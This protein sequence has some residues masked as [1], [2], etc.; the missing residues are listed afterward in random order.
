MLFLF[1]YTH[2]CI[3]TGNSNILYMGNNKHGGDDDSDGDGDGDGEGGGSRT[4]HKMYTF[5]VRHKGK[6]A[7]GLAVLAGICALLWAISKVVSGDGDTPSSAN[8]QLIKDSVKTEVNER[9]QDGISSGNT[10]FGV[11]VLCMV[12]AFFGLGFYF[13]W[14]YIPHKVK[15]GVAKFDKKYN[16]QSQQSQQPSATTNPTT[17][18]ISSGSGSGSGSGSRKDATTQ[19]TSLKTITPKNWVQQA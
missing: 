12:V 5:A 16:L 11:F 3:H 7:M 19:A 17:S 8:V 14:S 10:M 4:M 1:I 9:F 13:W 2:I 6:V 15:Q 18:G